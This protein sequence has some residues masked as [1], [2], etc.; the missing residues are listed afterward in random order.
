[1][2]Q[3]HRRDLYEH[4]KTQI[5]TLFDTD[6]TQAVYTK[7]IRLHF[8][9]VPTQVVPYKKKSLLNAHMHPT[10]LPD[11]RVLVPA[12]ADVAACWSVRVILSVY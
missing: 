10:L 12:P 9:A 2:R 8:Q 5:K 11:S 1:M 6:F 3:T 7:P 4:K